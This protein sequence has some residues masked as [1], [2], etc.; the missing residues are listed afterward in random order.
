MTRGAV[1]PGERIWSRSRI[2]EELE[3]AARTDGATR[4]GAIWRVILPLAVP[5]LATTA[6]LCFLEGWKEFMLALT[7]PVCSRASSAAA[8]PTG[9]RSWPRA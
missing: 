9:A 1:A 4:L 2:P 8:T 5:G 3:H 6:V 7:L